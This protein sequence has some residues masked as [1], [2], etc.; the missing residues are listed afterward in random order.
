MSEQLLIGGAWREGADGSRLAVTDPAT[1]EEITT[2]ASGTPGDAVAAV[3]AAAQAQ[4]GWAAQAPRARAEV[5]RACWATLLDHTEELA[6]LITREHGKPLADARAEI[7]YAAEFFRWNSEETVRIH[8]SIS[9]AP[10]G[11]NRIIVRHPPVGVVL[12]ITPW[13]FPAAM[14]TRKVAPA[15]AA[16]NAMVIKPAQETPLTAL[17]VAE[18][19][20]D[21]GVPP[22]VVN[23]VPTDDAAGWFEAAVDQ[24]AVRMVSFTGSTEVGRLLLRRS[25]DRVLKVAMELG[26]NAPFIVFGDADLDAAVEG[27]IVAKMRHSAQTCTAANRMFV[28]S[29]VV[30]D[31]TERL[32]ATMG[33]LGVGNG[34]DE[35]VQCGPMI[36]ADAVAAIENLVT[37]AVRAGARVVTGGEAIARTGHF[38]APTVLA[39][40]SPDAPI[41][42]EEVFGPVAPLVTFDDHD[43]MI[44]A[45]NDTEMGLAAYVYTEDLAKGLAVA[46]RLDAGMVGINRG[47]MSDPAAPFG[48]MKQSGLGREGAGEGIYEFCETQYI[49]ASW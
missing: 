1:G 33:A 26:G 41:T 28:E 6:A 18:L 25:A 7:A 45:A 14:I 9:T 11:G 17:R 20:E 13:N 19:L 27:A 39:G 42:R 10:G 43:A 16:G 22:G 37:D 36:S 35:G 31:F 24:R 3:D 29:T 8:G 34:F 46:E 23:V 5:L 30:D 12:M 38:F 47:T 32:G 21:A 40:V 2:V 48:G 44:G 15:L 4:P 49:A